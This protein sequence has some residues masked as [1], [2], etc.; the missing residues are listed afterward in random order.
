MKVSENQYDLG[1]KGQYILRKTIEGYLDSVPA[2][3]YY[4][5]KTKLIGMHFIVSDF[6]NQNECLI[7]VTFQ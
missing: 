2:P 5:I 4:T 6:C 7:L 3:T 1:I